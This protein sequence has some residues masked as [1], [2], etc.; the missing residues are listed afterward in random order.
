MG[1]ISV[2]PESIDNLHRLYAKWNELS[3]G[4][5][6]ATRESVV[7]RKELING[8][9]ATLTQTLEQRG[10]AI[11]YIDHVQVLRSDYVAKN[12]FYPVGEIDIP[13]AEDDYSGFGVFSKTMMRMLYCDYQY[14][15]YPDNDETD[16]GTIIPIHEIRFLCPVHF[17]SQEREFFSSRSWFGATGM[18]MEVV[19]RDGKLFTVPDSL[20]V[21]RLPIGFASGY[22]DYEEQIY[23][24]F[25]MP[26][27]RFPRN[28]QFMEAKNY[29]ASVDRST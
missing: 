1:V 23:E 8:R 11:C 15:S 10:L 19:E 18:Q 28:V 14:T 27:F 24:Q 9:V 21:P 22:D 20:E 12:R 3:D 16:R 5:K 29:F 17:P 6:V 25:G 2:S 4:G 26:L 13:R 7:V